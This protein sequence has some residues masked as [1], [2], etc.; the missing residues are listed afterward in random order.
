MAF[1]MVIVELADSERLNAMFSHI[2]AE[3]RLAFGL[4]ND[5]ERLHAPFVDINLKIVEMFE[6][7]KLQ[8]ASATLNEY[9]V[10]SERIV[11]AVYARRI[12]DSSLER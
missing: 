3:L 5:Q 7:G 9:L 2:L 12:S 1:K 6:A 10:Q 8:E 11:L 4:V